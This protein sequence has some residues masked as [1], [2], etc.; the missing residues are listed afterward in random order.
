MKT[1]LVTGGTGFIG[2]HLVRL[3]LANGV[4][5]VVTSRRPQTNATGRARAVQ[6]DLAIADAASA[7][8]AEVQPDAI[9]HLA[10]LA[11][12]RNDLS[13]VRP[14]FQNNLATSLEV[15]LAG[16]EH[17]V[18]R[19]V[20]AG[21]LDEVFPGDD[22]CPTS[23]YAASKTATTTYSRLMASHGLDVVNARIFMGYGPGQGADKLIP[24]LISSH[25][26]G[27]SPALNNPNRMYDWIHVSDI[28]SAL[29]YL[30]GDVPLPAGEFRQFDIGSGRLVA[31]SQVE[32]II[33]KTYGRKPAS[34]PGEPDANRVERCADTGPLADLG[35]TPSVTLEVGLRE[36]VARN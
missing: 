8:V 25:R 2:R 13:L 34:L 26:K 23:P 30:A 31:I 19:I 11:Y 36:L 1:V 4:S 27:A 7:L 14:M 20:M 32:S 28:A 22:P 5:V 9:I 29:S 10:G 15:L 24:S 33:A 17:G 35:W 12:G 18:R 3:L 6:V 21:S 16:Y